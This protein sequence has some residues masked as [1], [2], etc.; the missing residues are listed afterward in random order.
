MKVIGCDF[1]RGYRHIAM[2]DSA[3]A[4]MV[5]KALSHERKEEVTGLLCGTGTVRAGAGS[6]AL[7][8]AV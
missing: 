5:E 2:L 3:T 8:R 4:E 6:D 7:L 1:H